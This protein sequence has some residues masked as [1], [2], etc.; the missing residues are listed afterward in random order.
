MILTGL[1]LLWSYKCTYECD[2]CFV[3]GSPWQEGTFALRQLDEILRQGRELGTVEWICFEGGEP[4]LYYATLLRGIQRA[5]EEGFKTG[6]VT[7]TYWAIE[8]AD[9][10][11]TLRP[12]A[13]LVDDFSISADLYHGDEVQTTQVQTARA[14]AE[15]L[16]IPVRIITIAQ[17]ETEDTT[18]AIGQIPPGES[19]VMFRGRAAENLVERAGRKPWDSFTECPHEDLRDPGRIHIDP[20]GNVHICQGISLGNLFHTPLG[21]ICDTYDPDSHPVIGPILDGGPA[22][23]VRRYGLPHAESY[24]DACHLCYEARR[25]LRSRFPQILTPDQMYGVPEDE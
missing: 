17:P 9:A 20:L 8:E 5:K 2:H 22:E 4:F 1:H 23:L 25:D 14:A 10:L 12:F 13:G 7:N 19:G 16:R 18:E 11:E 3:W 21:T 24:A 15:K 6:I